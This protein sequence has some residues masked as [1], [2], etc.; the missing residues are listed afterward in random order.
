MQLKSNCK[1]WLQTTIFLLVTYIITPFP[2]H[3]SPFFFLDLSFFI[4][5]SSSQFSFPSCRTWHVHFYFHIVSNGTL[6][7]KQVLFNETLMD[8]KIV[9]VV[10]RRKWQRVGRLMGLCVKVFVCCKLM[11]IGS[12]VF[13]VGK[14]MLWR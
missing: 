2:L 11:K 14:G 4:I 7:W 5:L 6:G 13:W 9:L 12:V 1:N 8:E 10:E 3:F